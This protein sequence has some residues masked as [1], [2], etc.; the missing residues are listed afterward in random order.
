M[1]S[2]GQSPELSCF[3]TFPYSRKNPQ[4][5]F[6]SEEKE[7]ADRPVRSAGK[8]PSW[9]ELN[10]LTSSSLGGEVDH[11]FGF[12]FVF[13]PNFFHIF[14]VFIFVFPICLFLIFEMSFSDPLCNGRLVCCSGVS[15]PT[16]P[17]CL[18]GG[19]H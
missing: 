2:S 14:L 6:F 12:L 10:E 11:H 13:F 7:M 9:T 3:Y 16:L 15:S 8:A 1:F 18:E 19:I 5:V 4:L 17:A